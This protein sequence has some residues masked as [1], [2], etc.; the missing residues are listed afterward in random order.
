M[1]MC[2]KPAAPKRLRLQSRAAVDEQLNGLGAGDV[3]PDVAAR[4]EAVTGLVCGPYAVDLRDDAVLA[5]RDDGLPRG[6]VVRDLLP[7]W[8]SGQA[9]SR[10]DGGGAGRGPRSRGAASSC[11]RPMRRGDRIVRG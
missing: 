6:R 11:V 1:V 9:A 10:A 4:L 2:Y 8:R 7:S 5:V 3:E